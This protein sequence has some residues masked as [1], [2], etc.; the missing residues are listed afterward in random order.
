MA[1]PLVIRFNEVGRA[2]PRAPVSAAVI[3]PRGSAGTVAYNTLTR[4]TEATKD[5]L[6]T[7]GVLLSAYEH[8]EART[9]V[10]FWALPWD[11]S[12]SPAED[13]ASQLLSVNALA[14]AAEKQKIDGFAP[15]LVVLPEIGNDADTANAT[16]TALKGVLSDNRI[17][18]A[19]VDAD[20]TDMASAIAWSLVNGGDGILPIVNDGNTGENDG[21]ILA[22][23][24]YLRYIARVNIGVNPI[25]TSFPMADVVTPD[26]DYAFGVEDPSAP[27][28]LLD[29]AFLS[30]IITYAGGHYLWGGKMRTAV[31]GSPLGSV[32]HRLV[33]YHI[34]KD[35]SRLLVPLVG[36]RIFTSDLETFQSNAEDAVETYIA[37]GEVIDVQVE[38]PTFAATIISSEII[39]TFPD[40]ADSAQ[41]TASVQHAAAA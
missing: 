32:G 20:R 19:F 14:D 39:I 17:A 27:A 3:A 13:A 36:R 28:E 41:L 16:I 5:V 12:G 2:H 34:V 33:A 31:V 22:A 35:V 30:T 21:A 10:D 8:L 4:I 38:L 25:G 11:D 6:G 1:A 37:M 7:D 24:H 15:D 29:D 18:A 40:I 26:P 23:A 9:D